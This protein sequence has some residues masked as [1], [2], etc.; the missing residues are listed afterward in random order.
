MTETLMGVMKT[1][2]I[3]QFDIKGG[4]IQYKIKNTKKPISKKMLLQ[5]VTDF[6]K[7]D[8]KLA[9]SIS[10]HILSCQER[11]VTENITRSNLKT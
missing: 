1:N 2:D 8:A 5:S 9:E 6:Y 3:D 4:A 10:Q 7:G 11:V